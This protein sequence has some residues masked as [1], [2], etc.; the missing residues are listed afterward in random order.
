MEEWTLES[1]VPSDGVTVYQLQVRAGFHLP[2]VAGSYPSPVS[3]CVVKAIGTHP[4][5]VR[6]L[7]LTASPRSSDPPTRLGSACLEA[8]WRY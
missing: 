1:S 4:F 2:L 3:P 6:S 7:N 8:P 5:K